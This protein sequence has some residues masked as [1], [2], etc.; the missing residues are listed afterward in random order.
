LKKFGLQH[1]RANVILLT[2]NSASL[3]DQVEKMN[4]HEVPG[5]AMSKRVIPGAGRPFTF[6]AGDQ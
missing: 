2:G 6:P 3:I 4:K 1:R 5:G